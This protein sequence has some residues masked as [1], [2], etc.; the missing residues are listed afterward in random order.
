MRE[1][2][3]A[4]AE[5]LARRTTR[6]GFFS[7]GADVAFG[8]LIGAAAGTLARPDGAAAG[9]TTRCA[10]PGS[11]PCPCETCQA[12]GVCAKPCII[13]T[14][15]YTSGCWVTGGGTITCCDCD[16]QGYEEIGWC[17]CGSD[18]HTN[19]DLCPDGTA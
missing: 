4:L 11:G 12:N 14:F 17:G 9:G 7:R 19:P 16:C 10:F 15:W 5:G 18:Y 8:T 6:R 1:R 13:L 2:V 3:R